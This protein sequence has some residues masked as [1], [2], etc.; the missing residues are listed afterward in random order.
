LEEAL[1]LLL[2]AR[3]PRELVGVTLELRLLTVWAAV[4]AAEAEERAAA[5]GLR[6]G[7]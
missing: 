5:A 3:L 1:L 4:L 7:N 6:G 2:R